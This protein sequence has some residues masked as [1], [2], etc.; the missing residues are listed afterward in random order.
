MTMHLRLEPCNKASKQLIHNLKHLF[1]TQTI[2]WNPKQFIH[3]SKHLSKIKTMHPRFKKFSDSK[4]VSKLCIQN[5]SLNQII[6]DSKFLF[7]I[8]NRHPRLK[9][10]AIN[11]RIFWKVFIFK[12]STPVFNKDSNY[13]SNQK[14][15]SITFYQRHKLKWTYVVS[16]IYQRFLAHLIS[17]FG[18]P[19]LFWNVYGLQS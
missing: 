13:Y 11:P 5:S 7:K 15:N 4:Y 3:D 18:G 2:Y 16:S 19:L 17:A 12:M 14:L 6:R 1:K 8:Q 9:P 10:D